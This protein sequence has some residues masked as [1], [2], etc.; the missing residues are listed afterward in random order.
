MIILIKNKNLKVMK[1][2]VKF[3]KYLYL[4]TLTV[5]ITALA[6]KRSD[7]F[8]EYFGKIVF[9]SNSINLENFNRDNLKKEF[10]LTDELYMRVFMKKPL[11][12]I[13][14]AN[15][16]HY[17]FY[18]S[19][20]T[21]NYALRLYDNGDLIANWLFEMP[22]GDY[23][24]AISYTMILSTDNPAEKRHT[25][26]VVNQWADALSG[27]D[28]GKHELKLEMV[29]MNIDIVD[30]KVPVLASGIFYLSVDKESKKRFLE[31]HTT[32]LPPAAITNPTVEQMILDASDRIIPNA[33]PLKAFITD[34]KEDWTYSTDEN[35]N[36]LYRHI[37]ASVVYKMADQTCWVKSG[38][39][40]QKH[41]GYGDFGPMYFSKSLEGYYNY[42]IPCNK[43]V[44]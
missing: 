2:P 16:Y 41:E 14:D 18:N 19:R 10:S 32:N 43:V 3:R 15:D 11:E 31:R 38:V 27:L 13:Y 44:H 8:K 5:F 7:D 26:I 29:P 17:D 23:K 1:K 4:A 20:Y 35:G 28:P 42:A 36:I 39:Y 40:S 12:K 9:S 37:I 34:L 30:R 6:A 21:Y 33:K 24:N 25:S 22:P